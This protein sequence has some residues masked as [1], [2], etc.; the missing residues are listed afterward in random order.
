MEKNN[1]Q[2]VS[3]TTLKTT[4]ST[5]VM[6]ELNSTVHEVL[7]RLHDRLDE[8]RTTLN[9]KL[10]ELKRYVV[11]SIDEHEKGDDFD[12]SWFLCSMSKD[13]KELQD[14]NDRF[15]DHIIN[16]EQLKDIINT[17][18]PH[19]PEEE[20]GADSSGCDGLCW[21]CPHEEDCGSEYEDDEDLQ[22]TNLQTIKN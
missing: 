12:C 1:N 21:E 11:R 14:I 22:L 19:L 13:I 15:W 5:P 7:D 17:I 16:I 4:E 2:E 20:G 10:S 18:Q 8:E 3:E 6:E 9:S